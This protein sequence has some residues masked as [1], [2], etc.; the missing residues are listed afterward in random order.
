M[1]ASSKR[2][3]RSLSGNIAVFLLLALLG[4]FMALPLY[5]VI[6]NSF[7]PVNELFIFPP[8][9]Y[10]SRP[11]MDNFGDMLSALQQTRVPFERYL[12]NSVFISVAGTVVYILIASLA[13]YPLAK[14]K[15]KGRL[16]FV[17]L[18]VWAMLFRPE[19]LSIPQYV[20][21]S[22]LNWLNTYN[23][24]IVPALASSMGIFLMQQFITAFVPTA[25]I[26]AAKIDGANE[27]RIYWQI[28]MPMVKPAWLTLAIFTFQGLWNTTSSNYIYNEQ[29]KALP[30]ALTQISTG[31]ISRMGVTAAIAL[32]LMI[33]PIVLFLFCQS[34][35]IE[36]M[37]HSGIK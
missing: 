33:P 27:Y 32:I 16:L 23:A 30:L 10:I 11:T 35:V 34:S 13:A 6:I 37:S 31:G 19:I 36:T 12:F 17:N 5:F 7:K 20:I 3:S 14:H 26:E 21:I 22:K 25:L 9:L 24:V 8:R 2:V 18:V 29:M 15:F 28:I 4:V 1:R